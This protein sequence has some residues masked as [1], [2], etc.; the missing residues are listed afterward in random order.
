M[1]VRPD[2][3]MYL[4]I[5]LHLSVWGEGV[6][7]DGCQAGVTIS[8]LRPQPPRP[9]CPLGYY[10][11]TAD[12]ILVYVGPFL[13]FLYLFIILMIA[14]IYLFLFV[15]VRAKMEVITFSKVAPFSLTVF[16]W[17]LLYSEYTIE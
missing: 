16:I 10:G 13:L 7:G 9:L 6:G 2:I 4:F 15:Y 1:D 11:S 17:T 3:D 8:H 14:F 5:F 12:C